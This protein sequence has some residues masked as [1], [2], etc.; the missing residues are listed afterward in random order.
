MQWAKIPHENYNEM[1]QEKSTINRVTISQILCVSVLEL[2]RYKMLI[3][4]I[5][6]CDNL[7]HQSMCQVFPPVLPLARRIST[8][9]CYF[10]NFFVFILFF[11]LVVGYFVCNRRFLLLSHRRYMKKNIRI[12]FQIRMC[13]AECGS[14][15]LYTRYVHRIA[16]FTHCI[17][18]A[19]S[20]PHDSSQYFKFRILCTLLAFFSVTTLPTALA[21]AQINT[22]FLWFYL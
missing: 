22:H 20:T 16:M 8:L 21:C 1:A 9:L 4:S 15:S 2:L 3:M 19:A 11:R 17:L 18:K 7:Y 6:T 14:H 5:W 13:W 12:R 10:F